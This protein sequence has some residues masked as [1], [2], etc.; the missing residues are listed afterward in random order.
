MG[1]RRWTTRLTVE[2][3]LTFD[4]AALLRAGV[5]SSPYGS[6]CECR[7]ENASDQ[8]LR[9]TITEA[10]GVAMA[11]GFD[12]VVTD[13]DSVAPGQRVRYMIQVTSTRCRFGGR[14]FWFRCPLTR[15]GVPCR[16]RVRCLYLPPGAAFLACRECFNLTYKSAQQEDKRVYRLARVPELL[17]WA[18]RCNDFRWQRAASAA[19]TLLLG[20]ARRKRQS[21]EALL[22]DTAL[23]RS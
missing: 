15:N 7:W 10:P 19:I 4:A 12:Y 11:L 21:F 13:A 1:R 17:S 14:R 18:L 23:G 3:C 5:F 6:H 16:K 8:V 22:I 20:R 2:D 9:F